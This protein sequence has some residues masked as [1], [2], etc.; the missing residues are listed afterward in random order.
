MFLSRVR[1]LKRGTVCDKTV[2]AWLYRIIL[3]SMSRFLLADH[4]EI[5]DIAPAL[6]TQVKDLDL[7]ITDKSVGETGEWIFTEGLEG[8]TVR[9]T[10][11]TI[12]LLSRIAATAD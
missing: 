1:S 2:K 7:I 5:G 11:L 8:V 4:T 3:N 6:T 10:A 9:I 12:L